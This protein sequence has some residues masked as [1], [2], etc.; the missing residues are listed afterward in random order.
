MAGDE[1]TE[2][3]GKERE[4]SEALSLIPST[5]VATWLLDKNFLLSAY[6]LWF[7][8]EDSRDASDPTE[9]QARNKLRDFFKDGKRFPPQEL[10]A[11]ATQD[12]A[13]GF[14]HTDGFSLC[15]CVSG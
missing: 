1:D 11:M 9:P 14:K 13:L 4:K 10:A 6:E 2:K 8:L 12:G 5:D 7:E 3:E 15:P